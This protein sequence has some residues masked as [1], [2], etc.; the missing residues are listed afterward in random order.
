MARQLLSTQLALLCLLSLSQI[1]FADPPQEETEWGD[2]TGQLIYD[3][4]PPKRKRLKVKEG[5]PKTWDEALVVDPCSH[6]IANAFVYLR[7]GKETEIP[8]ESLLVHP[9]YAEQIKK[10]VIWFVDPKRYSPHTMLLHTDQKLLIKTRGDTVISPKVQLFQNGSFGVLIPPG[11]PI[12]Y[13]Y[14]RPETLPSSVGCNI[15]YW[16]RGYVLVR[17]NPYMAITD[18]EGK[19][20]MKNLPVGEHEFQFWQEKSGYVELPGV[21]LRDKEVTGDHNRGRLRLVIQPGKNDLGEIKI[22]PQHFEK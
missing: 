17:D 11:N 5:F 4:E 19:F 14:S 6:G 3:G 10:P 18:A 22:D 13:E 7:N 16:L 2:L 1:V 9:D 21:K 15:H 8:E 20:S 12:E